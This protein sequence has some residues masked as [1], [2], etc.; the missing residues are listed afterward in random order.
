MTCSSSVGVAMLQ[1]L[2]CWLGLV[3]ASLLLQSCAPSAG[4]ASA[5]SDERFFRQVALEVAPPLYA[6]LGSP[7]IAGDRTQSVALV[8]LDG[9][10]AP[11]TATCAAE[12]KA[13]LEKQLGMLAARAHIRLRM[14]SNEED[15]AIVIVIG[16][17]IREERIQD[18]PLK[19]LMS[20]ARHRTT[21]ATSVFS[22]NLGIPGFSSPDYLEA[23]FGE[24]NHRLIFGVSLIHWAVTPRAAA[25]KDCAFNFVERLAW[26]YSLA[27]NREFHEQYSDAYSMARKRIGLSAYEM[28]DP[29]VESFLG[30]YFC[31]QF[32]RAADLADC[33]SQVLKLIAESAR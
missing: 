2:R 8:F 21:T 1:R 26:L 13:G 17:T 11:P 30:V 23:L 25:A 22:R 31:A 15:A 27:L 33:S 18:S 28:P 7:P 24:S 20:V 14:T 32:A 5:S 6:K 10:V 4:D 29:R 12:L 19:T 9:G 3:A 16:D